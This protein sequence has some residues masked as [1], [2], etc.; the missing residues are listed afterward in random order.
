MTARLVPGLVSTA[1]T[2]ATGALAIAG[3]TAAIPIVGPAVAA[4]T[5]ALSLILGGGKSGQEKVASTH[6]VDDLELNPQYGLKANLA[7]YQA[8]PHT[9]T[10]QAVAA[11][12]FDQVWTY[13]ISAKACGDPGLED[14]GHNCI[15]DRQRGGK[16]DWF[17]AY[18]D[19]IANDPTVQDDPPGAAAILANIPGLNTADVSLIESYWFPALILLLA[20]LL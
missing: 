13:L 19:P 3:A 5:L 2:I 12:N 20:A 6:I 8:G 18:R 17:A 16:F 14:A 15:A 10:S 4:V 1:G 11:V 9:K 7:A